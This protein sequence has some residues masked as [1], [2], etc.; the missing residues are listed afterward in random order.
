ML[1]S[2]TGF[3]LGRAEATGLQVTAEIRSVNGRFLKV[4]I[5]APSA[6]S[7][8]ETE[9]EA[10]LRE[11]LKRLGLPTQVIGLLPGVLDNATSEEL[12]ESEWV[13]IVQ[14]VRQALA[15]LAQM[16]EREGGA[17]AVE[18]LAICDRLE[19]VRS[20]VLERAPVVVQEYRLKLSTRLSLLLDAGTA[21]VDRDLVAR[22]VAVF[23]DRCDVAEELMRLKAHLD[24]VQGLVNSGDDVGRRLDFLSQ[25]MLR[26]ANT[27]GSK[28]ADGALA[29]AVIELKS[30]IEQVK[31]QVAN[32][33]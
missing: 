1:R 14:A 33:E 12:P 22:E 30:L 5:K 24:Q 15:Q 17:L 7:N 27:I 4:S 29:H 10:L 2:M 28:S 9:L 3:G 25:E 8:R 13:A 26:E 11:R 32:V 21:G 18:L 23:A 6:L 31:E 16:R 20:T 19:A